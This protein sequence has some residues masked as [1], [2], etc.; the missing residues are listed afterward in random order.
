[1]TCR[2]FETRHSDTLAPGLRTPPPKCGFAHPQLRWQRAVAVDDGGMQAVV[3]AFRDEHSSLRVTPHPAVRPFTAHLRVLLPWRRQHRTDA[4]AVRIVDAVK[5]KEPT[6]KLN[7]RH[8]D[9]TT[10][11]NCACERGVRARRESD[12]REQLWSNNSFS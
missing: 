8:E 7:N 3:V 4:A 9:G 5:L 2:D 12:K 11:V 10:N 1:M 6:E